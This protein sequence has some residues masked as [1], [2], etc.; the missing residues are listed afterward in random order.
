MVLPHRAKQGRTDKMRL[1]L[2]VA[3]LLLCTGCSQ[4]T[5]RDVASYIFDG[6]PAPVQ[7]ETFCASWLA[8]RQSL[9]SSAQKKAGAATSQGSS[10]PPYKE[11]ECNK[12]HDTTKTG[13]LKAPRR[14]LCLLCHDYIL[15]GAYAHAPATSGECLACHLPHDAVYPSLLKYDKARLCVSCH[16]E[17][18]QA[19]G[20]HDKSAK[21]GLFCSDCHDPHVGNN[22]YFLK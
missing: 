18:R 12:C 22:R 10:H 8:A 14:E 6:M 1:C 5:R 17:Q 20:L 2:A 16:A 13:G 9:V 15:K 19:R 3:A 11:K 4:A 7:P 21:A